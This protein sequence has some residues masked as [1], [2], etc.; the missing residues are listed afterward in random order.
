MILNFVHKKELLKNRQVP[1]YA[2][3][4]KFCA[5]IQW[6]FVVL[7]FFLNLFFKF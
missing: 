6:N 7:E 4:I 2:F 5:V 3:A 1:I